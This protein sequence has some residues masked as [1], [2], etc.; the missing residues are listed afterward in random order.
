MK[1]THP[2][3]YRREHGVVMVI[4]L[5]AILLL[6]G[7]VL[8]VLNMGEQVDHRVNTQHA[9]DASVAAGAGWVARSMNTVAQNN[10]T[11]SRYITVANVMDAVPMAVDFTYR[12]QQSMHDALQ[13]QLSRGVGSG[14]GSMMTEVR[15]LLSQMEVDLQDEI[16]QLEPVNDLFLDLDVSEMTCYNAPGGIGRLWQAMYAL[17]E[18]SQATME[19]LAEL[20]QLNAASGGALNLPDRERSQALLIPINPRLPYERG[21]F[22]DFKRPVLNGLLPLEIDDNEE[23]RGPFDTVFG[24][25]R[26]HGRRVGGSWVPG[27]SSGPGG[28]GNVPIGGGAGG[29]TG[30][31]WVG[32]S[33]EWTHYS[34]WGWLNH[35]ISAGD[36][37]DPEHGHS[38]TI[39]DFRYHHMYYSRLD[40]WI[41]RMAT[42]KINYLWPV[43]EDD[44]NNNDDNDVNEALELK[45]IIDPDWRIDYTEARNIAAAGEPK[46]RETAF[47]VVEIKS[48]YPKTHPQFMADGTWAPASDYGNYRRQP[49]LVR[50]G[51]WHDPER[52]GAEKIV[53][54]GWRDEWTYQKYW[55]SEIGITPEPPENPEDEANYQLQT[56]YRY[57]HFYFAGVNVGE[58]EDVTN[59]N[60]GLDRNSDSAPA[61]LNL[62]HG[63]VTRQEE[64]RREY[65]T[66]LA[67]ASRDDQ[68][69]AWAEAF[70]SG[71]P[72]PRVVAMAQAKVFNSH[73]WDLWTPMWRAQ[74]EPITRYD[75][76]MNAMANGLGQGTAVPDIDLAE[77][78]KLYDYLNRLEPLAPVTLGH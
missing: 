9:A 36:W 8:W 35:Y 44:L 24:W 55:D 72:Y 60:E 38:G 17:D 30:G 54:H 69:Q 71:K 59:P 52:W 78:E 33:Y 57:D 1:R 76:W 68:P 40:W 13:R 6:V 48:R 21:R 18:V 56:V 31:S 41:R 46:I 28:R 45:T 37:F 20:T 64:S 75:L 65:L 29:G 22:D 61:P 73:S 7:L 10:L 58:P 34:T 3:A 32:G 27:S 19:N 51:G 16:D 39:T 12:E 11:I 47:F 26:R 67:V 4:T 77:A 62:H 66:F 53:S 50:V 23:R 74:I 43:N 5:L 63:S 70:H 42:F 25:H 15:S 49:R 2:V 14:P